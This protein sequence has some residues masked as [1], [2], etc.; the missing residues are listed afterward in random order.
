MKDQMAFDVSMLLL[1][2]YRGPDYCDERVCVCVCPRL[3]LL[4]YTFDL[5]QFFYA[6]YLWPWPFGRGSVL[7]WLRND[8]LRISGFMDGVIFAIS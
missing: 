2:Q 1:R 3:Y 8:M 4:K 5:H 7:L 6:S